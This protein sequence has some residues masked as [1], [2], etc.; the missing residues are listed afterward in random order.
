MKLAFT[1]CSINYLGQAKTLGDSLMKYNPDYKFI[2]GLVD[3]N[4]A[5][6][7]LS[8]LGNHQVLE[9]ADIHIERFEEMY[10]EYNIVELITA[11]KPFY[12][13]YLFK[14][15]KEAVSVI[16]FDPD[17]MVFSKFEEMDENLKKFN[18]ILTPHF[19]TP[20]LDNKL[21]TE[22]HVFN[23]GVFNLGFVA[24]K[25]SE[26][27]YKLLDWWM[28]KLR[29]ECIL[30]LTRGYF[31][32][33]LWMNLAPAYFDKVLIEKAPGYNTAHWNLHERNIQHKNGVY[34]VNGSPLVFFHFSHFSL[35]HP[36]QIASFHTR[37]SFANRPD[38]VPLFD[39]YKDNLRK[40]RYLELI[41]VKCFYVNNNA[42]KAFKKNVKAFLRKN[43]P[44]SIKI[45]LSKYIKG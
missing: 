30:D 40:N 2:I 42:K 41:S 43:V 32:D 3:K 24:M 22:K 9:V 33:Q 20:I 4:T 5:Q 7:D 1:L 28:R 14:T 18:T 8:F 17:I 19:T 38:I 37:Y 25:R 16:Y 29:Y 11:V 45:K 36:D 23:T 39:L 35:K 34:Y 12:F 31:V 27:T 15:Y 26:E 6:V 44:L 21:P 10:T 13:D